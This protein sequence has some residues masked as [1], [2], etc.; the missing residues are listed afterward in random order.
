ME[1]YEFTGKNLDQA[2]TKGLT[3]L[4]KKREEVD[5]KILSQG[6]LFSKAK[7]EIIIP[8]EEVTSL[9]LNNEINEETKV[10]NFENEKIEVLNERE[11]EK[12]PEEIELAD[13]SFETNED[14]EDNEDNAEEE[15]EDVVYLSSEE[16]IEKIQTVFKD[17]FKILDLEAR[18]VVMEEEESYQVKIMGEEDKIASL[19]GYRGEAL[20]AYQYLINNL[21][22][23][24]N[25]S[26]RILLDI[27]NYRGR[28]EESIRGLARKMA[29]KVLKTKRRH[30][31]EP[32]NAYERRI[33]HDE[34]GKFEHLSTHSE[35]IE[36]HRYLI[37]EYVG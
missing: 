24:K 4:N 27:E 20:N 14:N 10:Q 31:F 9:Q 33:I 22:S 36:P 2:I 1:R 11:E 23:L 30:K 28:R 16:V 15:R 37:V 29:N 32:M 21:P 34:I 26:K 25:K 19:I 6:G 17:I 35:G 3:E 8:D 12:E 7:V 5:I 13:N 18:I